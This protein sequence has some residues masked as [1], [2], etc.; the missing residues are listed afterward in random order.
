MPYFQ[1]GGCLPKRLAQQWQVFCHTSS[2]TLA[3]VGDI[4]ILRQLVWRAADVA[5]HTT[6]DMAERHDQPE[7]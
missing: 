7:K 3:D 6:P 4:E 5:E 1:Q 2:D